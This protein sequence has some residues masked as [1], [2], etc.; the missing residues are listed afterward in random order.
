MATLK[1]PS[2]SSRRTTAARSIGAAHGRRA[3]RMA[4]GFQSIA[5]AAQ[6]AAYPDLAGHRVTRRF[7]FDQL[8]QGGDDGQI[9]FLALVA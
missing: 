3:H 6:A 4:N 8:L 2:A 1:V 5:Q 9:F 7:G